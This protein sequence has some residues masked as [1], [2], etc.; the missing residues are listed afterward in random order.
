MGVPAAMAGAWIGWRSAEPLPTEAQTREIASELLPGAQVA[1]VVRDSSLFY[2]EHEGSPDANA[3]AMLLVGDDDYRAGS[4][5]VELASP[6]PSA[7]ET[8]ERLSAAGW[9]VL[10]SDRD[11][12]VGAKDGLLL[13]VLPAS[14]VESRPGPRLEIVR[15]EPVLAS[16]LAAVGLL[17]G[18]A[19]GAL[20]A[21]WGRRQVQAATPVARSL[22]WVGSVSGSVMVLPT[23]VAVLIQ[24]V[25]AGLLASPGDPPY[26]V[27]DFYMFWGVRAATH[28]GWAMLGATL[29]VVLAT[30]FRPSTS[31]RRKHRPVAQ[32]NAA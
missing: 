17:V 8:G 24:L 12:L 23:A 11:S 31:D 13:Y 28:L 18:G 3:V 22:V 1:K 6:L 2:Y 16:V 29:M 4:T 20:L 7:V 26:P 15:A 10:S 21:W 30:S 14:S 19:L 9:E 27:W 5:V 32:S 25:G